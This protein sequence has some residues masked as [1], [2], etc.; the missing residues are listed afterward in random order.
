M[1]W[2]HWKTASGRSCNSDS[3]ERVRTRLGNLAPLRGRVSNLV[4][5]E[6]RKTVGDSVPLRGGS[7]N[8][9]V[10][11]KPSVKFLEPHSTCLVEVQQERKCVG[12]V[13]FQSVAVDLQERCC[14][15][16]RYTFVSI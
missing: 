15:G 5:H 13:E 7:G 16:H 8:C 14:H 1:R 4:R 12:V 2:R 11:P 10:L 9:G 6:H 3:A